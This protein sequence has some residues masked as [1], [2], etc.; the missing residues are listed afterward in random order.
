VPTQVALSQVVLQRDQVTDW[1][2]YP[3]CVPAINNFHSIQFTSSIC[4]LTGKNDT[5]KSTLLRALGNG[6]D[7]EQP[8]PTPTALDDKLNLTYNWKPDHGYYVPSNYLYDLP[9]FFAWIAPHEATFQ[10]DG[11]RSKEANFLAAIGVCFSKPGIYL[12]DEP[13][14]ELNA[15]EQLLMI[16][17]LDYLVKRQPR[18]QFIISTHSSTLKSYPYGQILLMENGKIAQTTRRTNYLVTRPYS[19]VETRLVA[20]IFATGLHR[21]LFKRMI[22]PLLQG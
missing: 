11:H 16:I 3:Y 5:G 10:P 1:T 19:F 21:V 8:E 15:F 2:V 17:L 6:L 22:A 14:D 9:R 20:A 4:F 13:E 7:V 12:L 18:I